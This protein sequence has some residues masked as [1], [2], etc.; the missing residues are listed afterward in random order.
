MDRGSLDW[1]WQRECD[2]GRTGRHLYRVQVEV[3]PVLNLYKNVQVIEGRG[4]E[5]RVSLVTQELERGNLSL[6]LRD[7]RRSDRGGDICQVIYK[8]VCDPGRVIVLKVKNI[9]LNIST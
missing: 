2:G 5:G 1:R 7:Y 9:N 8:W 4:Y 3:R 6:R